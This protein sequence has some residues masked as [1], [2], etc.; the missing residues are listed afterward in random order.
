M[1]VFDLD[2]IMETTESTRAFY[3]ILHKIFTDSVREGKFEPFDIPIV[4]PR[5]RSLSFS[6]NYCTSFSYKG[7][8][9]SFSFVP[10]SSFRY[11][12]KICVSGHYIRNSILISP[13]ELPSGL[14]QYVK[15]IHC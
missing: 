1:L 11:C 12:L 14:M 6:F 3:L 5:F 8:L 4:S 7:F 2:K 10:D 13:E 15:Y 9:L